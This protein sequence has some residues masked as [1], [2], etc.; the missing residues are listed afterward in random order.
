MQCVVHP[1]QQASYVITKDGDPDRLNG[2][3]PPC[4]EEIR[5]HLAPFA[6]EDNPNIHPLT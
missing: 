2:V 3:C 4:V 5:Q 1:D 6:L